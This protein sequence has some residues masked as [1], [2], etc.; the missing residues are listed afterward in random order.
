MNENKTKKTIV[1][2]TCWYNESSKTIIDFFK[3]TENILKFMNLS[4]SFVIFDAVYNRENEEINLIKESIN[5]NVIQNQHPCF[6]N[7][8]YG[9]YA[10]VNVANFNHSDYVA[11]VDSDWKI[12]NYVNFVKGLLLPIIEG[13]SEI[14]IPNIESSAGRSNYMLGVPM[15]KLFYPEAHNTVKTPFPGVFA[16]VTSKMQTI[17]TSENYHFDWGG[18]WDIVAGAINLNLQI[19]SSSLGVRSTRHRSSYSKTSDAFQIWRSLFQGV[20]K[21]KI[22]E[23]VNFNGKI[24]IPNRY[25]NLKNILSGS[26]SKQVSMFLKYCER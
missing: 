10:I 23:V 14:A 7:K 25:N 1:W 22:V 13:D 18:E 4:Y 24:D 6:P 15:I 20:G 11:V 16:A 5:C 9:I 3:E 8:N 19:I 26:A 2:G 12:E 17:I 21:S